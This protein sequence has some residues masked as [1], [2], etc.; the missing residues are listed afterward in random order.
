MLRAGSFSSQSPS[1]PKA[2]NP[3]PRCFDVSL[4]QRVACICKTNRHVCAGAA[5]KFHQALS[6]RSRNDWVLITGGDQN[7]HRS[8]VRQI[9]RNQRHHGAEENGCVQ[10][11]RPKQQYA[12]SN[13]SAVGV[14]DG[15]DLISREFVVRRC[16][17]DEIRKFVRALF[18]I[19]DVEHTFGEPSEESRH[20]IFEDLA[21]RAKQCGIRVELASKWDEIVFVAAGSMQKQQCPVRFARNEFVNEIQ[22]RHYC[23]AGSSIGSRTCSIC[24]RA[25]SSHGGRRSLDPSSSIVSSSVKPGGSVAISKRMPPGSRK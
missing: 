8:Q 6:L 20:S 10:Y 4:G 14:T 13:I 1:W 16:R 3:V 24:E 9:V 7:S 22:L 15:D 21:A 19:L 25:D 11:F 5:E 18:Q 2:F 17:G 23:L 12:S